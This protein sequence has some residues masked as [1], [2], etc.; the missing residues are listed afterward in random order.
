MRL[1][2]SL[3]S[4]IFFSVAVVLFL[5]AGACR[6]NTTDS[7]SNAGTDTGVGLQDADVSTDGS[8]DAWVSLPSK[9]SA[10]DHPPVTE[11]GPFNVG[12]MEMTVTHQA[13]ADGT[14]QKRELELSVWYPTTDKDGLYPR[15]GGLLDREEV[16]E[17]A[18]VAPLESMPMLVF[19]HGNGG[20]AEQ[21]WFMTERWASRGWIAVSPDH[22]GNT[23]SDGTDINVEAA[24]YRPQDIRAVIDRM[25]SLESDHRLAGR[26]SGTIVMSGHSFGGYTTL[27]NT[28]AEYAVEALEQECKDGEIEGRDYCKAFDTEKRREVFREGFADDRID[29]AIPQAPA[30]RKIF[31]DG[32]EQ[33]QVPTLLMTGGMDRTLPN[34]QEGDPIWGYMKGEEH[35]RLNIDRAGHFTFS[36]MC[37]IFGD[38]ERVKNDGCGDDNVEPE[39]A[40]E[41]INAYSLAFARYQLWDDESAGE[42]VDGERYPVDRNYFEYL[43]GAD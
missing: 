10:L 12:Y 36:N 38:L 27:A 4:R 6:F 31:R 23:I 5:F 28:G 37:T 41:I 1:A 19:S 16:I 7:G 24:I 9:Y 42:I 25:T 32:H 30:G 8:G 18:E 3:R 11:E 2:A 13:E 15:Y 35:R 20:I 34:D 33:I 14:E 22:T 43:M 17:D 21:N 39:I 40:F 26:F 29:L